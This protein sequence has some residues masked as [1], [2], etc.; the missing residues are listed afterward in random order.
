VGRGGKVRKKGVGF[1]VFTKVTMKNVVLWDVVSRVGLLEGNSFI[2]V[3]ARGSVMV[4]VLYYKPEGNEV[5]PDEIIK[6]F[7]FT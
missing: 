1:Q 4:E 6:F 7:Q 2:T 5:R 3:A